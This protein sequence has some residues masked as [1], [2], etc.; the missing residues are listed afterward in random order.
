[1]LSTHKVATSMAIWFL[2]CTAGSAATFMTGDIFA[3][4]NNGNVNWYRAN[5]TFVQT[6]N[7][8]SGYTTGS[9]STD[10]AGNLYV[11]DFSRNAVAKFD[12]SGTYLGDFGSG[13]STPESILFD[14]AGNAFVGN[15]GSNQ[16][17]E[18]N[19]AGTLTKTF[20]AATQNRGTD[21]IE[22]GADQ[23]TLYYTSEGSA[24]KRFD[25]ATNTQLADFA[26]G[27]GGPDF[28]NRLLPTGGMLVADSSRV[29]RL[30][31]AGAIVQ[32]YT[33]AGVQQLFALNLDPDGTSF[34]TGDDGTGMLYKFDI[35][36]GALEQTLNTGVGGGN[37]FG[38]SLFGEITVANPTP[39]P[40]QL[41]IAIVLCGLL[42]VVRRWRR[43][44]VS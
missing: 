23:H 11:T 34:W 3:S 24:V 29:V 1:M 35:A 25:T 40:K 7:H 4:V 9:S 28:A 17:L 13:Y 43:P 33:V 15:A 31:A 41:G 27:L 30:N 32:S 2:T 37:L 8:G 6:I 14:N 12:T 22:L 39:E 42:L 20:L 5:G 18:F 26:T 19:S 36:T 10:A 21:W 16:I 38:V 44:E